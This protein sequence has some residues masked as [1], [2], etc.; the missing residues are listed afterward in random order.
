MPGASVR[1]ADGLTLVGGT[2][3]WTAEITEISVDG[4]SRTS[5]DV[6]HLAVAA[7]GANTHGNML[8][9]PG[10]FSDPG[11]IQI[12]G[13]FNPDTIPPIDAVPETWTVTFR[14]ETGDSTGS[15]LASSGFMTDFSWTG[16]INDKVTFSATIKRSGNSTR[17]AAT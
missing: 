11:S 13:H 9:K 8:F 5:I 12:S 1:V 10:T 14:T 7:P 6:T 16:T 3:A 15:I 4:I 17:T 2:S